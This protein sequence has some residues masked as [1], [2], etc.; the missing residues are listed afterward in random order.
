MVKL[1]RSETIS[2]N[3]RRVI[4]MAMRMELS[5]FVFVYSAS[6]GLI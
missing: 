1:I 4:M 3:I 2:L 5:L 6:W